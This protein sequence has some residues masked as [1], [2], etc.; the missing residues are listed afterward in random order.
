[1]VIIRKI[2]LIYILFSVCI[3]T[4]LI[5]SA[6]FTQTYLMGYCIAIKATNS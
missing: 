5:Y 6:Y 2:I 4:A 1:V 3:F